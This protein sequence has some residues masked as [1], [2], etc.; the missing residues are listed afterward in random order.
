MFWN[1]HLWRSRY[2]KIFKVSW[3]ERGADS[4]IWDVLKSLLSGQEEIRNISGVKLCSLWK[5]LEEVVIWSVQWYSLQTSGK[6]HFFFQFYFPF[7][8]YHIINCFL[9]NLSCIIKCTCTICRFL[10]LVVVVVRTRLAFFIIISTQKLKKYV[11]YD[12][13]FVYKINYD[14]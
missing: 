6:M 5:A 9:Y 10:T 4:S 7:L 11:S 14:Q 3:W 1:L 8:Y 2:Y 13:S 12:I